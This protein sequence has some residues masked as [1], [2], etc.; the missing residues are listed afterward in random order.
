MREHVQVHD[1]EHVALALRRHD[2]GHSFDFFFAA[3]AGL[4]K[5]QLDASWLVSLSCG[6]F[7]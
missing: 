6:L 5:L 3:S 4:D 7:V 1:V 2:P